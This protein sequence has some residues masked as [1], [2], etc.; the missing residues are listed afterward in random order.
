MPRSFE[1]KHIKGQNGRNLSEIEINWETAFNSFIGLTDSVLSKTQ[2]GLGPKTH[3]WLKF[4]TIHFSKSDT[5]AYGV[6]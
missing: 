5:N 3:R 1:V 6:Q 4:R 2:T